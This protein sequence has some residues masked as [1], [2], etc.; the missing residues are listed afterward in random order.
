MGYNGQLSWGLLT[1]YT[2]ACG[3]PWHA[4]LLALSVATFVPQENDI[5]HVLNQFVR[6]SGE[7]FPA[8]IRASCGEDTISKH[9]P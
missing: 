4:S 9:A 1:I 3:L 6:R 2:S 7:D 5:W 8:Y